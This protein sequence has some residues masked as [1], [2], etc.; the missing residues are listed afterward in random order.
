METGVVLY[1]AASAASL[2]GC[3]LHALAGGAMLAR[4]FYRQ[5][6]ASGV[7]TQSFRYCWH[8]VTFSLA[9]LAAGF[10]FLATSPDAAP[11]GIFLTASAAGSSA[12][13]IVIARA[14]RALALASPP[15]LIGAVIAAIGAA[16]LLAA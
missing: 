10:A 13:S 11:L 3:G 2:A 16:A 7:R 6:A 5:A 9:M 8:F 1:A 4:P 12:L 15:T 14:E